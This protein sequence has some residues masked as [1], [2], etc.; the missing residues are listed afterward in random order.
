MVPSARMSNRRCLIGL[1]APCDARLWTL[2]LIPE[3]RNGDF[4]RE[5][6]ND[7][8]EMRGRRLHPVIDF[9]WEIQLVS[10]SAMQSSRSNVIRVYA[11]PIRSAHSMRRIIVFQMETHKCKR[12]ALPA[13]ALRRPQAKS[14]TR[15]MRAGKACILQLSDE[16][17][18]T[19]VAVS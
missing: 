1:M 7:Q 16:L 10:I 11:D 5:T 6:R 3:T 2:Q 19:L 9:P 18:T 8:H 4:E 15:G 12:Y 17:V 13:E 14:A